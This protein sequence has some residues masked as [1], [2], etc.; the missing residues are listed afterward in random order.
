MTPL[1]DAFLTRPIAH[2]G[3]HGDGRVE[4]SL[5]AFQ[6]AI[7]HGYG[8][9][10]DIQPSAD[11][12]AMAFHDAIL[13][14]L[15]DQT[16]PV[17][18]HSAEA[19]GK[20]SLKSGGTIPLLS[21][22]LALVAGRVPVLIEIKDQDGDM[23]PRIGTLEA[24]IAKALQG[25]GGDV[26]LMSFNPH[27]VAW[28][29]THLPT[30]AC[31]LVTSSFHAAHWPELSQGT[32]ERLV[33]IPDLDRTGA[34]FIS[35]EAADLISPRVAEIRAEGL[36]ILCWTI[37]SAEQEVQARQVAHNITFEGYLP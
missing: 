32:R 34:A 12:I 24:A 20:I 18:A 5:E 19:L 16:G 8:I 25:Y 1:P 30:Y 36:P 11:G 17:N 9:E 33:T 10:L 15:T 35:H 29:G 13:D 14:R 23:G 4:N 26:A 22:A 3:L 28:C 37:R 27:S 31:G 6:A 2:R 21:E 7:D